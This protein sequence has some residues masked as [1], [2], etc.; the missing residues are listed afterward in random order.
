MRRL[1]W[2]FVLFFPQISCSSVES[3]FFTDKKESTEVQI[4]TNSSESYNSKLIYDGKSIAKIIKEAKLDIVNRQIYKNP[5]AWIGKIISVSGFIAE[6]PPFE[7]DVLCFQISGTIGNT[8]MGDH[9]NYVVEIDHALPTQSKINED[10]QTIVRGGQYRIFARV[11][12]LRQFLNDYGQTTTLPIVEC[13]MIYKS[14]D[15]SFQSPLWVTKSVE[16]LPG[17]VVEVDSLKYE[18]PKSDS[19][20][21][22]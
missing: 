10:V 14:D 13:L 2:L 16:T 1:T 9:F 12:E 11:K 22:K 18:F 15:F 17:G 6:K 21:K 5:G 4:N 8:P 19:L 20:E 3:Y 7:L